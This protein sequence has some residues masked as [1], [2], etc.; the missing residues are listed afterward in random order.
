MTNAYPPPPPSSSAPAPAQAAVPTQLASAGSRVGAALL[1]ALLMV[2]TLF[3]GWLIWSIVLWKQSTS[4]AK[5]M[6]GMVV[7]DANT[8]APASV[9]Q[10]VMREV[11][12]KWV[13]GSVTGVVTLASIVMLW[14]T[15]RR[16]TVWDYIGTTTVVRR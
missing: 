5:K 10:M 15:P 7:L 9:K 8:G 11:V 3:I 6:L 13:V 12:G 1:D 14:A 2:V 4:P 16:Q